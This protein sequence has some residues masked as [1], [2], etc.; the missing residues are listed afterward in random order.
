MALP[1]WKKISNFYNETAGKMVMKAETGIA[2][3][4]AGKVAL[5]VIRDGH[6][7]ITIDRA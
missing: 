2:L 1:K 4:L 7:D 3:R 5:E 6:Q